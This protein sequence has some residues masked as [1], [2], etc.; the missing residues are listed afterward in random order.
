MNCSVCEAPSVAELL[1]VCA[2]K[3][4]ELGTEARDD[5]AASLIAGMLRKI[6]KNVSQGVA[7]GDLARRRREREVRGSERAAAEPVVAVSGAG[8]RNCGIAK[9]CGRDDREHYQS[10]CECGAADV[11]AEAG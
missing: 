11:S 1:E 4:R 2:L 7:T 3:I 6:A 9:A 8:D 5:I 10:A